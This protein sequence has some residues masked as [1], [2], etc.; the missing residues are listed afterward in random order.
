M[1]P[2]YTFQDTWYL[3]AHTQ[4]TFGLVAPFPIFAAIYG[5]MARTAK[6]SCRPRLAWAHLALTL[7]SVILIQIP[8]VALAFIGLPKR[9]IDY[10]ASLTLWNRF[11]SVGYGLLWLSLIL[12]IVIVADAVRRRLVRREVKTAPE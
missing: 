2:D 6:L 7:A 5:F 11:A 1:E 8:G 10:P 4:W 9:Y 12:F 3:V